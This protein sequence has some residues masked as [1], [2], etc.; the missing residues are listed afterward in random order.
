MDNLHTQSIREDVMDA[1]KK[2]DVRMRPRWHFY[3]ASTICAAG[4]VIALLLLIYFASLLVFHLRHSGAWFVPIFGSRGWSD[5]FQAIPLILVGL[6]LVF[7]ILLSV[8]S[9]RYM[10]VYQKPLI[11][12]LA[13]TIIL[14]LFAGAIVSRTAF[15]DQM[16]RYAHR[17]DLPQ[18][19]S[20]FY[21]APFRMQP[22]DMHRGSIETLTERGFTM[23]EEYSAATTTVVITRRTRLPFGE[24]FTTGMAV[25][26]VGDMIASNTIE[27]FG[28]REMEER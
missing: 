19:V 13:A 6:I 28:V 10:F 8:L 22:P 21:G 25:I 15:H 20:M 24:D 7:I 2:G 3:G 9:R 23:R 5:F 14:I 17:N 4:S 27:A 16:M 11:V 18:F 26:V 12:S 1:I